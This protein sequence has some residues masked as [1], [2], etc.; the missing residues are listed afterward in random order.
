VGQGDDASL[1]L[2]SELGITRI[3]GMTALSLFRVG[4][5]DIGG[6]NLQQGGVKYEWDGQAA[7]GM[8]ERS[9]PESQT[10]IG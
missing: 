1:E 2:E 5:P 8:I 9:S 6:L 10:T 7:Y 4:N 3:G